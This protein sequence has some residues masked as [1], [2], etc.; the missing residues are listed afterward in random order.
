MILNNI[1]VTIKVLYK[2]MSIFSF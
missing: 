2:E 1:F